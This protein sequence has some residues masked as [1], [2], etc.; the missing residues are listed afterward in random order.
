MI[1][2]VTG[3]IH[4]DEG[5]YLYAANAVYSGSLP[6]RDFFF[7][8]PPVHPYVYGFIQQFFPG[9]L[10][11]HLTS[12][13]LGL[14]AIWILFCVARRLSGI[15]GALIF[16]ALMAFNPFQIYFFSIS[17]LY[18]LTAMLMALGCYFLVRNDPPKWSWTLL[19]ISCFTL[20]TATRLTTAIILPIVLGA[21]M[22]KSRTIALRF[23]PAAA[24]SAI[25]ILIAYPFITGAGFEV[26]TFNLLGMNLSLHTHNTTANLLQKI[27]GTSQLIQNYFLIILM[28]FSL[29]MI[30]FREIPVRHPGDLLNTLTS[31]KSV[32]W[33]IAVS[34]MIIQMSAKMYQVSY[35]T[36]VMPLLACL[37]GIEW[38]II[39]R[40]YDSSRQQMLRILFST[41]CF[42]TVFAYGRTSIA[43]I[44][45]KP[46]I[47]ALKQQADFVA[48]HTRPGDMIF[49]ADSALVPVEAGRDILTGM[50]GSDL[51]PD[52]STDQCKRYR[53]LNFDIMEEYIESG[54]AVMVIYG[55]RS[56]TLSLPYLEP[57]AKHR[58]DAF[59]GKIG[60]R[61][62]LIGTFPNLFISGTSTYYYLLKEPA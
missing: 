24:A 30:R 13:A 56:F 5:A 37:T 4:L 9:Y 49:S 14:G 35:Q 47:R 42:L 54:K 7:L 25:L 60:R 57:I 62:D 45:G 27:R 53:V 44:E 21:F 3:S 23:I 52:W 1:Y 43:T 31:P 19:S 41:G 10:S 48:M 40:R 6:Y 61:Y 29:M 17:R 58:R 11:A 38:S 46:S 26:V 34:T 12:I 39:F 15:S 18:A 51:F 8:Q 59:V 36:I 50:A 28:I 20:M 2:L 16:L 33:I 32:L 22:T 55:D